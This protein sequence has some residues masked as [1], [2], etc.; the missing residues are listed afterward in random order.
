MNRRSMLAVLAT[1]PC[2]ALAMFPD[3]VS[4]D[5]AARD[6]VVENATGYTI[7]ALYVSPTRKDS[8]GRQLLSRSLKDGE[9]RKIVFKPS[10][11]VTIYDLR[12]E[13]A[14]G[15]KAEW[16]SLDVTTFSRLTIKWNAKTGKSSVVKR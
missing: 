5:N 7:D 10:N 12:A 15:D 11:K 13:Y 2:A 4:A 1:V 14:D 3:T 9:S 8:W 16:R 6:F